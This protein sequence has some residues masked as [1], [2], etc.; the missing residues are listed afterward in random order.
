M[1]V[2]TSLSSAGKPGIPRRLWPLSPFPTKPLLGVLLKMSP[3]TRFT[4]TQSFYR[5]KAARRTRLARGPSVHPGGAELDGAQGCQLAVQLPRPGPVVRA[6]WVLLSQRVCH[7]RPAGVGSWHL[8]DRDGSGWGAAVSTASQPTERS[9]WRPG[10]G[11]CLP[12]V[13]CCGHST[14]LSSR[15]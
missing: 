9:C 5:G 10:A 15:E 4:P 3:E 6:L 12:S 7:Y 1:P 14:A 2:G 8:G 13:P 11:A